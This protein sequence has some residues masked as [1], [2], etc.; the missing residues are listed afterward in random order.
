MPQPKDCSSS[1]SSEF[2]GGAI[3]WRVDTTQADVAVECIGTSSRRVLDIDAGAWTMIHGN[4]QRR[5]A[6]H[7]ISLKNISLNAR[8]YE[9]P[10]R[11][12]DDGVIVDDVL[13]IGRTGESDAEVAALGRVSISTEPVRTE[14][15]A[16]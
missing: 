9:D 7:E 11:I 15:V 13:L 4:L 5:V 8:S 1:T 10:I 3:T 2:A 16:T 14:P 6:D 12:S